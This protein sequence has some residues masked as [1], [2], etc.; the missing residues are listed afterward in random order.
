M[1]VVPTRMMPMGKTVPYD[2]RIEYLQ[3]SGSQYIVLNDL[4][5]GN[6]FKVKIKWCPLAST[7]DRWVFGGGNTGGV[8][9]GVYNNG[10]TVSFTMPN[11]KTAPLHLQNSGVSCT[12]T[13]GEFV[14][15]TATMTN[16]RNMYCFSQYWNGANG[17]IT[18]R[19]FYIKILSSSNVLLHMIYP[20]RVG[21]VGYLF[22]RHTN[23][24]FGNSG[25][26][27][28]TLGSDK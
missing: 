9:I 7:N 28:F 21:S 27:S 11:G 18:A 17:K 1:S 20:V 13:Q 24:I 12:M 22:D 8:R 16:T 15:T 26:G 19:L 10:T 4:I 6:S 3:S 23:R 5:P 25:T 2:R 14:E